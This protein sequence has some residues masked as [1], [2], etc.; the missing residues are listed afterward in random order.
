MSRTGIYLYYANWCPHCVSFKPIWNKIKNKIDNMADKNYFYQ[1]YEA[2]ENSDAIEKANVSGFPTIRIEKNGKIE[3]YEG[4]RDYEV[5]VDELGLSKENM[6]NQ[7]GGANHFKVGSK[8]NLK[9]KSFKRKYYKY[10]AKYFQLL[11]KKFSQ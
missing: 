10:K 1:E 8:V 9:N 11:E 5:I 4:P 7:A 3:D 6:F 2:D